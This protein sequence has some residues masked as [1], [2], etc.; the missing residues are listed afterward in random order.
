MI[1]RGNQGSDLQPRVELTQE[2]PNLN[3][4]IS[5][6]FLGASFSL[7]RLHFLTFKMGLTRQRCWCHKALDTACSM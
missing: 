1:L 5:W 4:I 6:L 3:S 7:P 2:G